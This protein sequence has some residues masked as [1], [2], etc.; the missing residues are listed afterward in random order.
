MNSKM[1]SIVV[2]TL[3]VG[4]II[5]CLVCRK[6]S[7]RDYYYHIQTDPTDYGEIPTSDRKYNI[8]KYAE[9]QQPSL[10]T[11]E[12]NLLP[13]V[14]KYSKNN[15]AEIPQKK[16]KKMQEQSLPSDGKNPKNNYAEI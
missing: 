12:Y 5:G 4:I 13:S 7:F 15:Y 1:I 2:L 16:F 9:I 11:T 14:G 10:S 8:N 6:E 3:L